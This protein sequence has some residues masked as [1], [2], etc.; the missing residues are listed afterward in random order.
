MTKNVYEEIPVLEGERFLLR[1]VR[2]QDAGDLL[3]VYSD[4]KA[5]P[6]FN[7]D[8]CHGDDFHYTTMERI[9]QALD[10][11]EFSYQKKYFVRW[12]VYDKHTQ[13]VVGSVE[14]FNRKA[15]DYFDNCGLLRLDLR[16]DYERQEYIENILK[17]IVPQ[18]GE[19]FLCDKIATKA[20]PEAKERIAALEHMGFQLSEERLIGHD[21]TKYGAYFVRE[22]RKFT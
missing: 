9:R 4:E 21:G 15:E 11:W 16:S 19:L 3:E 7:S 20:I 1:A 18:T 8:N 17:L 22:I 6:F 10:F 14:L 13:T 2:E 5:V 12:V